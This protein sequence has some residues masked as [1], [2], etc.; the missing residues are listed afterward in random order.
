ML[1]NWNALRGDVLVFHVTWTLFR[2]STH[3]LF[4]GGDQHLPAWR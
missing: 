2:L 4:V 1:I 3:G